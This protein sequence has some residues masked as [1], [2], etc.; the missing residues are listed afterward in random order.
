MTRRNRNRPAA[1]IRHASTAQR[2]ASR[3][4]VAAVSRNDGTANCTGGPGPGPT[5]NVNAPRTGW[6]SAET[7]R[8]RTRYQPGTGRRTD[9]VSVRGSAERAGRRTLGE[10]AALLVGDRDDRE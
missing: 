8:Q 9:R 6:P 3:P 4:G 5:A 10:L 7:T 2:A 1:A